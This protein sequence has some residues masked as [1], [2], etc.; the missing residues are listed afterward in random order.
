M[1]KLWG[2]FV[3]STHFFL[4]SITEGPRHSRLCACLGDQGRLR[5]MPIRQI[6][7]GN[8]PVWRARTVV[9]YL[10]F[11]LSFPFERLHI[12]CLGTRSEDQ[13]A[14]SYLYSC[15][16]SKSALAPTEGRLSRTEPTPPPAT[17]ALN[18]P[19]TQ[20]PPPEKRVG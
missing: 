12:R 17:V 6:H 10:W 11:L 14:M 13:Q 3:P 20:P 16:F 8:R 18:A 7:S 15:H 5:S 1:M 2:L 9:P 19:T 4:H